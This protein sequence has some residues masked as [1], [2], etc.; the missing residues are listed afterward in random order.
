MIETRGGKRSGRHPSWCGSVGCG[1]L[2]YT[3]FDACPGTCP[4]CGLISSRG[5]CGRQPIDV[6]LSPRCFSLL[7]LFPSLKKKKKKDQAE[8]PTPI[9]LRLSGFE[10]LPDAAQYQPNL[11]QDG[12]GAGRG[13][14]CSVEIGVGTAPTLR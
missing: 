8:G 10:T 12:H 5:T 3:R 13:W 11:V 14:A 4:G 1:I 6:L 7:S 2:L 9:P